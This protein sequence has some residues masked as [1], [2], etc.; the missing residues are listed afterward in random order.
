[1]NMNDSRPPS[2]LHHPAHNSV[3]SLLRMFGPLLIL[4]GAIFVLIGL[5]DFFS[6]FNAAS[7]GGFPGRSGG[8]AFPGIPGGGDLVWSTSGETVPSRRS[9]APTKFWC[10]FVGFPLVAAGIGMTTAGYKGAIARYS[11]GELAPVAADTF[12]YVADSTQE[13]VRTMVGGVVAGLRDEAGGK[14]EHA[15]ICRRCGA[16]NDEASK[17]CDQC[18][19][20]LPTEI[21]CPSCSAINDPDARFC[22]GCGTGLTV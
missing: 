3:R 14:T 17:F 15:V 6:A 10:L 22:D 20:G 4:V 9:G 1:M 5:V 7:S 12:N 8:P 19:D 13:G 2:R 16:E 11:A 18:G 21:A